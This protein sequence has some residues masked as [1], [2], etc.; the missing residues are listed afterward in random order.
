MNIQ[1]CIFIMED[2]DTVD[3]SDFELGAT[4]IKQM[5]MILDILLEIIQ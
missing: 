4:L 1:D 2:I 5:I 3:F